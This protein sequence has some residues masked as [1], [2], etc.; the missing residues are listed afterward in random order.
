MTSAFLLI[1][2]TLIAG[3]LLAALGDRIG[4]RVGRSRL[5]LFKLRPRQTAVLVTVVTGTMISAS[6]LLVLLTLSK[7]LRQGLFE[8]H[9]IL[10][11]RRIVAQEIEK[12]SQEKTQ[13]LLQ[14]TVLDK[15][16][17]S[18]QNSIN[19]KDLA[20]KDKEK[21]N[22][23]QTNLLKIQELQFKKI[24]NEKI[25][26][27]IDVNKQNLS[28]AQL[29]QQISK[30]NIDL[31]QKEVKTKALE[32]EQELLQNEIQNLAQNY[33]DLR[34]KN[35]AILRGQVLAIAALKVLD[36]K[37]VIL[38]INQILNQANQRAIL[39]VNLQT[40]NPSQRV[41]EIT[42]DQV[43]QL[44]KQIADGKE[45]VIRI[46]SAGNY[47]QGEKQIRVFA[48]V[49]LNQKIFDGGEILAS[50]SLE[51]QAINDENLQKQIDSLLVAA[52]FNARKVGIV[53][54]IQV[55]DGKAKILVDFIS[56]LSDLSPPAD[57][58]RVVVLGQT[59][60]VGPL[61]LKLEALQDNKVVLST[62]Q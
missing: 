38:A 22:I 29:D 45:H 59:S 17:V 4:S 24:K 8:L 36:P 30:K 3:G 19:N 21:K 27:Q 6:T 42:N 48:D 50:V 54:N 46:L 23:A 61:K 11:K 33:Q 10:A 12:L 51:K 41:V 15:Q 60:T 28:I 7:S 5:T 16:I 55:A 37:S 2:A 20:L 1:F 57:R 47:V 14:T 18:L 35:I 52:E 62:N 43:M 58:I 25:Q 26:L 53:G 39:A 49:V 40:K 9:D 56:S 34:Q 13:L 32:N 44:A 31:Q